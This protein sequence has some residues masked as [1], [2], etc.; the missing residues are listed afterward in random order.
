MQ[1]ADAS[2]RHN[3]RP[4]ALVQFKDA[5]SVAGAKQALDGVQV[6]SYMA[7][8][9]TKPVLLKVTHSPL[10]DIVVRSQSEKTRCVGAA[11]RLPP[12]APTAWLRCLC[13]CFNLKQLSRRRPC[14]QQLLLPC[15]APAPTASPSSFPLTT[16]GTSPTPTCRTKRRRPC[17]RR[18]R[19]AARRWRRRATAACC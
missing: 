16:P 13:S 10:A 6:P 5:G 14:N 4:Q 7:P 18:R 2:A 8:G 12:P 9:A 11:R 19:A 15:T 3:A 1:T 17:P